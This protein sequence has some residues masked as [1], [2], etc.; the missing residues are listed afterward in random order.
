[1][2]KAVKSL[3]VYLGLIGVFTSCENANSN[4]S[5]SLSSGTET[6]AVPTEAEA[7]Q[8]IEIFENGKTLEERIPA[9]KGFERV[10]APAGSFLEYT[11]QLSLKPSNAPVLLYNGEKKYA[12]H[13][14]AA[15]IDMEIGKR[16]LQQCA[17]AI[18]RLRAEYL[19]QKK[20]F[21]K[22]H[23]NFTS[24]DKAEYTKFA[25]G[26]RAI[27]S[28]NNVSWKKK[29][30]ADY[31]YN[32]FRKY[33]DLVF[34][35]A[36]T[37]S[38]E[39]ELIP[40]DVFSNIEPGDVLIQGGHPGHAVVVMD[41]AIHP[42]SGEKVFLLAQSYMPA[43]DIHILNNPSNSQLSPWYSAAA[44]G[45]VVTPEWLFQTTNLKRFAVW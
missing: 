28:G 8:S 38:L 12:Q 16:D 42:G 29:E 23:Y 44:Q 39:K 40:V 35:Y 34:M 15:V 5:D 14:H 3:F 17:D 18:M 24:G 30:A 9:P 22:I 4:S 45:D 33:M 43:Q 25:E 37:A 20:N 10:Q 36:G 19:F 21:D 11:R 7:N 6:V 1:M 31:S 26:Y 2:E 41:V 13:V 27:V 32:T